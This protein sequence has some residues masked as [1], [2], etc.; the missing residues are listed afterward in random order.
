M[1]HILDE[2]ATADGTLTLTEFKARDYHWFTIEFTE[3]TSCDLLDL[4]SEFTAIT[5]KLKHSS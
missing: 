2:S 5:I 1:K 4:S 3:E